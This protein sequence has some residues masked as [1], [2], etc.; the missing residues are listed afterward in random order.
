MNV[1]AGITEKSSKGA[2]NEVSL[3]CYKWNADRKKKLLMA[4]VGTTLI[5]GFAY[6]IQTHMEM[7]GI[8]AIK[9][10]PLG[11]NLFL[12]EEVDEGYIQ[13]FIEEEE[14]GGGRGSVI[15]AKISLF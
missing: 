2:D 6:N 11:G 5:P 1:V 3:F 14:H 13:D 7:K 15:S 4:Y 12:M 9:I 10:I 8:Y